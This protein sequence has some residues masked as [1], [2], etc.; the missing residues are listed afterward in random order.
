MAGLR[1]LIAAL[2]IIGMALAAQAGDWVMP[3]HDAAHT[4]VADE[5]VEP[6]LRLL[7]KYN[8]YVSP[9][10]SGNIVYSG[11]CEIKCTDSYV[12]AIDTSSGDLKWK[13]NTSI[14]TSSPAVSGGMVFVGTDTIVNFDGFDKATQSVR[15]ESMGYVYALD[16]S[17]GRLIWNYKTIR[18]VSSPVISAGILYACDENGNVY[19]LEAST[20]S[21]KWKSDAL[22]STFESS[23]AVSGGIVYV[24][25][26]GNLN[27]LD[28]ATGALKWKY[29]TKGKARTPSVSGG[30]VF[31]VGG[32]GTTDNNVYALDAMT[33]ALKWKYKTN[34]GDSLSIYEG[35]VYVGGIS[36]TVY[37]LD[38]STGNLVWKFQFNA[39]T[40]FSTNPA[41]SGGVIYVGSYWGYEGYLF[42]LNASTGTV[43]WKYHTTSAIYDINGHAYD[44]AISGGKIYATSDSQ[45]YTF[46]PGNGSDS[47]DTPSSNA[48]QYL[49]GGGILGVIAI[50]IVVYSKRRRDHKSRPAPEQPTRAETDILDAGYVLSKKASSL[51]NKKDYKSAL[52]T[53]VEAL[54]NF[55]IAR[56][57][58]RNDASL[59][60]SIDNNIISNRRNILACKFAI[61]I[62]VS[63]AA[64]SAFDGERCEDAQ[65]LYKEALEHFEES[66]KDAKELDD[67]D[68]I[69]KLQVLISETNSNITS[70]YV[71]ADKIKVEEI[72]EQAGNLIKEA[73]KFRE[74]MEL[75][76][77][78]NNLKKAESVI[79][80]AFDIAAKRDFD[81]AQQIL[82]RFLK[83]VRE[84]RNKVDD[85]QLK[86]IDRVKVD[87]RDSSKAISSKPDIK[88]LTQNKVNESAEIDIK[89]GWV[90][91][92]NNYIKFGIRITNNLGYT[93]TNVD[94]IIDY[95]KNLFSM[96]DPE[97]QHLNNIAPESAI[98]AEYNLKPLTCIHEQ[99]IN[100]L[101]TYKDH[102]FEKHTVHMRPKKVHCVKPHLKEKHITEVEYSRLAASS[103]FVQEGI[104]FKGITVDDLAKIMDETCRHMLHKVR[105]YD[106]ES[107]KVIY[108]SGESNG[109]KAYYLLTAVIQEYKGLTQVVLR[110]HSDKKYGLNGFMNEMADSLRLLV[111][112]V[113]NAKEI[114]IIENTQVINIIDSVVQR[115]NF[116]M[117]DGGN[118][119][120]NIKDS[121]VQRSKIGKEE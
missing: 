96:K 91:L 66:L 120:V 119:K 85:M 62:G 88:S 70:C 60:K 112:S 6:P 49:V 99:Q 77:A 11:G 5:V 26:Y 45:I 80:E 22:G 41:V 104:S 19:A 114:G 90:N 117:G 59:A 74:E 86:P 64:K 67:A 42:A 28:A 72:S 87:K 2:I 68:E 76:K 101:I 52:E 83:N 8:A 84:E 73:V 108:L 81:E 16:A 37:A 18:G 30:V 3:G 98:T 38:A 44:L 35:V 118:T 63:E 36:D 27:A 40:F 116:N 106:L 92:P 103:E 110:A 95:N 102:K 17:S 55:F 78:R 79:E 82:S 54:D 13:Y 9:V 46:I 51:F 94:T 121:V 89:R 97:I 71:T 109:E 58:A 61:G 10:V 93:I 105:E 34:G 31:F 32:N 39:S 20:G 50:G 7:W 33:G 111:E 65:R 113:Q 57:D 4:G 56:K 24:G 43:K 15:S 69:E 107:K 25:S 14:G 23:P 12:Y 21:L 1:V 53:Y 47:E 48:N 100:A 29:T 115:T 75:S